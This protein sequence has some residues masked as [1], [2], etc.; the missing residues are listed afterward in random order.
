MCLGGNLR[1]GRYTITLE[2]HGKGQ[3]SG[4]Q[5]VLI[6]G[7]ERKW[8]QATLIVPVGNP[9]S[10]LPPTQFHS[11]HCSQPDKVIS[12]EGSMEVT[13]HWKKDVQGLAIDKRQESTSAQQLQQV[14]VFC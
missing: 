14:K 4:E 3:A 10:R 8:V 5:Q 13:P 1:E 6:L 11:P 7:K 2:N 12:M 9:R